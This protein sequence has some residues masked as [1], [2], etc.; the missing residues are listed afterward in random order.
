MFNV[1]LIKFEIVDPIVKLI[2]HITMPQDTEK[3]NAYINGIKKREYDRMFK[4]QVWID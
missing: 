1:V 2:Y 3:L 4:R